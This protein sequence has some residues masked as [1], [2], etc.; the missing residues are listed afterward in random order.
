MRKLWIV[1]ALLLVFVAV[2]AASTAGAR[3]QRL[4]FAH[5]TGGQE[6]PAV[7]TRAH[8]AALLALDRDESRLGYVVLVARLEGATMAHIHCG[9]PGVNGPVVAFL[10]GPVVEGVSGSGLL[11]KGVV[12]AGDV[13]AAPDSPACPGGI[14]NFAD[15]VAKLR[16][17]GAY[18]NVHT[19][20]NPTG[21]IRGTVQ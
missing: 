21:E 13:I 8:G 17:G 15:L 11:A 6:V 3:E 20:A 10:F 7:E 18:V 12:D 1:G 14:A 5:L 9:S 19:L 2:G 4:F 16:D